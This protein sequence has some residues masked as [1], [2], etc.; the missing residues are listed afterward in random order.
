MESNTQ[1]SVDKTFVRCLGC[2]VTLKIVE[3]S[4]LFYRIFLNIIFEL[5][6]YFLETE[7]KMNISDSSNQLC[8]N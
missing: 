4:F 3:F 2:I 8:K 7:N 1:K 5:T 6:I